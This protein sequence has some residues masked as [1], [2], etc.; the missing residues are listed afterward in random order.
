VAGPGTVTGDLARRAGDFTGSGGRRGGGGGMGFTSRETLTEL[1][2]ANGKIAD[3]T[4]RQE[5]MQLYSLYEIAKYTRLRQKALAARGDSVPGLG[6]IAKLSMS[7]I[8]RRTRDLGLQILGP[9]GMLHGY[10]AEDAKALAERDGNSLATGVTEAALF[11]QGPSIYGGTDEIQ[12]NI[13]G[14]RVLGL[15]REPS[16]DRTT[17]FRELPRNG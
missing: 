17:P 5:L 16:N 8:L 12:H 3:A 14:E 6:N 10:A 2:T 1:A 13:I 4:V 9:R 15:P 7:E 11:A